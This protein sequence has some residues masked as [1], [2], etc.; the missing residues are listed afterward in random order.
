MVVVGQDDRAVLDVDVT[1][2]L[3]KRRLGG[4]DNAERLA[5]RAALVCHHAVEQIRGARLIAL[6]GRIG[7]LVE[8]LVFTDLVAVAQHR[9]SLR[10]CPSGQGRLVVDQRYAAG[11]LSVKPRGLEFSALPP[12]SKGSVHEAAARERWKRARKLRVRGFSGCS[13]TAAGGPIS[14]MTPASMKATR[15]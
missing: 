3:D 8:G 9:R 1:R 15:S 14:T 7:Q 12:R 5:D 13:S 10:F 2:H 11:R 4:G 6:Q